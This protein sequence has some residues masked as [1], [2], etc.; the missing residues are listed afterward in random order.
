MSTLLVLSA[1]CTVAFWEDASSK[2]SRQQTYD[3]M[4]ADSVQD[5]INAE[6]KSEKPWKSATWKEYW[7]K[8]CEAAYNTPEMGDRDVE[9]VVQKRR[10]AG[11]PDI[12][13]L[14]N[15]QFRSSWQAFTDYVD[16]QINRELHA[17]PPDVLF[18]GQGA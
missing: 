3:R 5:N 14:N 9:Y 13:E 1:G 6:L 18:Y 16:E 15:R 10:S 2:Q 17:E 8:R 12:P 7:I 4:F 11:L